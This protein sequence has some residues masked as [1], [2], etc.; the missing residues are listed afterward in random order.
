MTLSKVNKELWKKAQSLFIL[1][2][3][4]VN[5]DF[6]GSYTSAFK[7]QGMTFA[8]FREYVPGDDV[9]NIYWPLTARTGKT[10]IKRFEEE[11]EQVIFLAMDISASL[12]FGSRNQSKKE[13]LFQVVAALAMS[14]IQSK[15]AVGLLLFSSEVE[16]FLPPARGM[17]HLQQILTQLYVFRPKKRL[18]KI[19]HALEHLQQSLKKRT[20]IFICS[21]FI[22]NNYEKRLKILSGKHD[23][24]VINMKDTW[25]TQLSSS[26]LWHLEDAETG[27]SSVMDS[28]SSHFRE[29]YTQKA[30]KES[31]E[32]CQ[33]LRSCGVDVLDLQCGQDYMKKLL[34]FFRRRRLM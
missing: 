6:I 11:R 31:Q 29:L 20:T 10:F 3:K 2:K 25:E 28:S 32:R 16:F 1:T 9:R 17:S 24:I 21:D 18:T 4:R 19:H 12:N 8:D 34:D 5:Q 13:E 26:G 30:Q 22:D 15:D 33:L 7:G 27:E 14:A 23:V